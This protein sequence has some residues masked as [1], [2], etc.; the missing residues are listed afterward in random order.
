MEARQL[1]DFVYSAI[2]EAPQVIRFLSPAYKTYDYFLARIDG[3]VRGVYDGNV[4]GEFIDI[5]A[6]LI[7][8]Q[9]QDAYDRA[10]VDAGFTEALPDYLQAAYQE[11]VANQY[12]FVDGF[13]RAIVD[14]RIDKTSV[15]PLMNRA[16]LWA[17]QWNTEYERATRLITE[18]NGGR[19]IWSEG[20][21]VEKCDQCKALD[22]IVAFASEWE[23]LGVHPKGFPNKKLGCKGGHCDCTL[24]PT[25]KRRSPNAYGRIEAAIRGI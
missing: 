18:K 25:D 1:Q 7:S 19:M 11:A 12:S 3:L 13:Y 22:G 8:G 23:T 24:L 4:G 21:T 5:F 17:G 20:D 10:W 15:T 14:A 9:F 2:L 16:G 6:N